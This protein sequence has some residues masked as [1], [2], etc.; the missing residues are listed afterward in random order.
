MSSHSKGMLTEK[1][2][3]V[4]ES[5]TSEAPPTFGE[6][7]RFWVKLGFISFGGSTGQIALM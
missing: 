6:A 5:L 3:K 2:S 1:M 7:L 4:A